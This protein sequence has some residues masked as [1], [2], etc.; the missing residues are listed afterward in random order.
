MTHQA[1]L[2]ADRTSLLV[3]V[4]VVRAR[5]AARAPHLHLLHGDGCGNDRGRGIL[6]LNVLTLGPIEHVLP[7]ERITAANPLKEP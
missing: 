1:F 7:D 3:S 2:V 4:N 6:A 5:Y